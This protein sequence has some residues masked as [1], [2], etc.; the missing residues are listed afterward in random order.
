MTDPEL[1][2]IVDANAAYWSRKAVTGAPVLGL[3][4]LVRE[5][6]TWACAGCGWAFIDVDRVTAT[7]AWGQAHRSTPAV[8]PSSAVQG[9][10]RTDG[11]TEPRETQ[12]GTRPI[13]TWSEL[14]GSAPDLP[15]ATWTDAGDLGRLSVEASSCGGCRGLGSHRRWCSAV[16]GGA[17]NRM[18]HQAE[19]A[20]N[21]A[22]QVGSNHPGAANALYRAAGLLRTEAGERARAYRLAADMIGW[23]DP[24]LEDG[25]PREDRP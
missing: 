11:P 6:T 21:L 10:V 19:Q 20:E 17:A 23:L 14:F 7:E 4:R 9:A 24:E 16:V 18:G 5:R 3:H 8:P 2:R 22:D 13:A 15:A 12:K 1:Q 25:S